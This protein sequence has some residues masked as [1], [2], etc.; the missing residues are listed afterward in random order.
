[1]KDSVRWYLW[2]AAFRVLNVYF[3]QSQFD[4]DEYWQNLEPS[5]CHVFWEAKESCPGWTWEW[6]RR[7]AQTEIHSFFDMLL[8]GLDG[9]VRSYASIVP[10]LVFY[11][12]IKRFGLDSSWMVSRG[13]LILNAILVAATTDWS[14]WYMSR[15]I[16][17]LSSRKQTPQQDLNDRKSLAFW[18]THCSL[19]S[20]FNAYTLVRTY[21]NSIETVLLS[22]SIAL[23]SPVGEQFIRYRK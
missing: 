4:P 7:P 17:P 2:F 13:P 23:C 1:M 8:S 14:I 16:S 12:V 21:S 19:T 6:K 18:C 15:W 11:S 20:W 3:I 10:T 5:Y 22:V 9:P